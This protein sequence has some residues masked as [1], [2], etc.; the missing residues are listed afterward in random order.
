MNVSNEELA[1]LIESVQWPSSEHAELLS[2]VCKALRMTPA[3]ITTAERIALAFIARSVPHSIENDS[4]ANHVATMSVVMA[5][6][7]AS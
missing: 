6:G 3:R 2:E 4:I 7:V 1:A 5:K